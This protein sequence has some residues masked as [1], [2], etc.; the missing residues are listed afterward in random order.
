MKAVKH[1]NDVGDDHPLSGKSGSDLNASKL[2]SRVHLLVWG[3]LRLALGVVQMVFA[4]A[5]F[6]SLLL[7]GLTYGAL[8]CAAIAGVATLASRALYHRRSGHR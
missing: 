5:A 2:S 4:G 1:Q 8:T 3:P 6:V 7:T